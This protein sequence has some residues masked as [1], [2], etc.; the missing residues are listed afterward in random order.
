MRSSGLSR[1][2]VAAIGL[3]FLH[4]V[5]A[6]LVRSP[7]LAWG[8]DDAAFLLLARDLQSF[9]YRELQDVLLPAHA[10]FPPVFPAMLALVGKVTGNQLDVLQAFVGLCSAVSLFFI[11]DAA[12]RTVGDEIAL[13]AAA[14][15]AINPTALVDAGSIMSEVPFKLF[16]A[17]AVWGV[18][19]EKEGTRFVVLAIVATVLAALTRTAGIVLIPALGL[20]WLLKRRFR[21]ALGLAVASIAVVAWL[22]FTFNAPDA[23]DRRLYV[24]E[25]KVADGNVSNQLVTSLQRIVPRTRQ[26]LGNYIPWSL[27]VPTIPGTP[28][29]NAIWMAA[30]FVFGLAGLVALMKQ[31]TIAS[32]F[33]LS[34]GA[35]LMYWKYGFDR[36]LRPV[37]PLM[38]V[39][40]LTGL[41]VTGKRFFPRHS[42][43]V[44]LAFGAALAL[45]ALVRTGAD[46]S[47]HLRCDRSAP[48]DSPSCWASHDRELL[49]LAHWVRDSTPPN[50]VFF[51]SKERAFFMHSSRKSINQDGALREDSTT[52]A[53]YLRS[54]GVSYT[55]LTPVG[56][57]MRRHTALVRSACH[58]FELV[59]R[60]SN[61]TML[62]RLL[63]QTA[64]SDSATAC[65]AAR[66]FVPSD[67]S[68][69][70][71]ETRTELSNPP[72]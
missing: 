65:V 3:A 22:A 55:V 27:G 34:Y 46:V 64:T 67:V 13:I 32:V 48:A 11:F 37:V 15:F 44:V 33:L 45:G 53:D 63:P 35:L 24:A 7:G 25:L 66:E 18:V 26:Y 70:P 41:S 56:V 1:T 54:R 61:R 58:D 17:L 8:E 39:T 52:I 72:R 21:W 69:L 30:L 68:E 14:L 43:W 4:V 50:A 62:L 12:R 51:V 16:I 38:L 29:D 36:L 2:T 28:I 42:R 20:Y 23:S 40:I 6:W 49:K 31:W 10:R 57:R 5:L 60:F 19:R 9:H 71:S 59:K 47:S